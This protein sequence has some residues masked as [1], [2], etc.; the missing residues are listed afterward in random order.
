M[1]M[2]FGTFWMSISSRL[3]FCAAIQSNAKFWR[4]ENRGGVPSEVMVT[5]LEMIQ[6]AFR[7]SFYGRDS[8][9]VF[10][11]HGLRSSRGILSVPHWDVIMETGRL[12]AA[13]CIRKRKNSKSRSVVLRVPK[14]GISLRQAVFLAWKP[15]ATEQRAGIV[16]YDT[17]FNEEIAQVV[18]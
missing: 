9:G 8:L 13:A 3:T 11:D 14:I 2:R 7:V 4:C 10:S 1:T 15:R 16:S 18:D 6:Y 17:P 12:R 5:F